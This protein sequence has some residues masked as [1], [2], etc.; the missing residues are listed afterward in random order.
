VRTIAAPHERRR[1][2]SAQ[3]RRWTRISIWQYA[4]K[5]LLAA[6][7]VV[8][9]AE[10]A[11]RNTRWAGALASLPLT[12][13]PA[14]IWLHVDTGSTD[15]VA[16]LSR[17]VLWLFLPSLTLFVSLPWLLRAGLGSR[18]SLGVACLATAAVCA[19][20]RWGIG[21]LGIRA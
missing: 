13:L 3:A 7:I 5:T 19:A 9:I 10:I 6:A 18:V 14:F 8:A 17:N 21:R 20:T 4:L 12:S 2:A 16:E 15:R 1:K 11:K